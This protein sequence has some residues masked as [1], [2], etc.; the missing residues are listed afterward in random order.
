MSVEQ[1][2]I[3][4]LCVLGGGITGFSAALAFARALPRVQVRLIATPA[5]PA[6]L[7]DRP[8]ASLPAIHRFHAAIGIDEL[9]LVR[10]GC[11]LHHL[12]TRFLGWSASGES[13]FHVFGDYGLTADGV[14]F[15]QI[16]AKLRATRPVAPYDRFAAA[17]R[18]AEAG[19]FVHPQ[20]DSGSPLSTYLYGLRLDPRVYLERL[21]V[22]CGK[23]DIQVVDGEWGAAV[24]R[25]DGGIAAIRLKD[26]QAFEADLFIDCSGP[27]A[28]LRSAVD[29]AWEDWSE[30]LPCDRLLTGTA[31]RSSPPEPSDQIVAVDDGWRWESAIPDRLSL[32]LAWNSNV[33]EEQRA[34]DQFEAQAG[35][36][37]AELLAMR[38]GR[39]PEPWKRNVLALGESAV[40]IDPLHSAGLHLAQNAILRALELLPG[41]D[42]HP[43][44]L[45]EYNRRTALETDRVRDFQALHYLR[46]GR[47]EG[48]FWKRASAQEA[49]A[50]LAHTLEQFEARGRL[51]FHDEES[52]EAQ[53]WL[54]VLFGMGVMPRRIDPS[55]DRV[56]D[57]QAAAAM[58]GLAERLEK[59]P[60]RLP[61]YSDYL[62]RMTG[63]A[64]P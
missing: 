28:P 53:S 47:T 15:H 33:T 13:W 5:D 22:E 21:V 34:V 18:L 24:P 3:R 16:W 30:W 52:F 57:D 62:A 59:L 32:G 7:A 6:A 10:D 45:S 19:K 50:S 4:S 64:R 38:P 58:A 12:G 48:E 1:R 39:R 14:P 55:A 43:L 41:R 17:A 35:V 11:A 2:W 63:M 42:C 51:P 44:E 29:G 20:D 49:P 25:D 9:E 27:S 37:G 31:E 56:D 26:G 40:S 54:A 46:S 36:P 61:G 8:V 60:D 23:H